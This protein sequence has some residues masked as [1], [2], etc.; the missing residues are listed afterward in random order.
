M[1]DQTQERRRAQ[2]Y[3]IAARATVRRASGETVSATSVNVSSS[4]ILLQVEEPGRFEIGEEV[5]VELD[6]PPDHDQPL[7]VWGVGKIVRLDAQQ[8]A[9]QLDAGS[10]HN[11][12]ISGAE[13]AAND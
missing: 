10:F 8:Q 13:L 3:P 2:R 9:I 12:K 4:G 1:E 7:S 6:L 11:L 5:S